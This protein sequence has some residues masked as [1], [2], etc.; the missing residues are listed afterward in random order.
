MQPMRFKSRASLLSKRGSPFLL[1]IE[2]GVEPSNG[3]ARLPTARHSSGR[4][5]FP[6]LWIKVLLKD[7]LDV[8]LLLVDVGCAIAGREKQ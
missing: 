6:I 3:A 1:I 5:G 8:L 4:R 7:L 2:A